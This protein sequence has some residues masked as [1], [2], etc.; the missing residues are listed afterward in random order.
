METG[1]AKTSG[2]AVLLCR[3]FGTKQCQQ[4]HDLVRPL[5]QDR[6]I[7]IE[8]PSGEPAAKLQRPPVQKIAKKSLSSLVTQL[9]ASIVIHSISRC[10]LL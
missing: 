3:R 8:T 10:R 7:L 5:D 4:L 2:A 9:A 1:E 6:R